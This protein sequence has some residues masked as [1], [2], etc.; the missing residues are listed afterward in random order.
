MSSLRRAALAVALYL[1]LPSAA[2]ASSISGTAFQDLDRD[3]VRGA[4]EPAFAD[5]RVYLF[6]SA[7]SY[8]ANQL[9]G[10]NG[11]YTFAGLAD[12]DYRVAY[13]SPSW[14]AV[15]ETWVPTTTGSLHPSRDVRLAGTA[16][17]DFGW[18]PLVRS[19]D[20]AAPI[21][22]Y[23]G[24]NG[25]TIKSYN[26]AVSALELFAAVTSGTV[27]VEAPTVTIDF[28]LEAGTITSTSAAQVNGRWTSFAARITVA[29]LNWLDTGDV[30][31]SHEYGHAWTLYHATI[32]QQDTQ[33]GGYLQ[34]RGLAGDP[35]V[36][37]SYAWDRREMAAEDYRQLLGSA[38]ARTAPQTNG[39]IPPAGSVPGLRDFLATAFTTAPAEEQEPP[40]AAL[41]VTG[42]QMNPDPVRTTGTVG[43]TLSAPA[44]VSVAIQTTTGALV[45]TLQPGTAQPAGPVSLGWD[46]TNAK[47]RKV[48]RGT[49][50]VHVTATPDSGAAVTATAPFSVR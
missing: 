15:R 24:A 6:D 2:V 50:R 5:H 33:F 26:D 38:S 11:A 13:A 4:G 47:G 10:A 31:L 37:S 17:A 44:M 21:S 7:G 28:G 9:T 29:Y 42:L 35:R 27:G 46:R 14:W 18:R 36:D 23:V 32:T 34:A 19:A 39:A 20:P 8:V 12:G 49:Y 22:T 16:T 41:A 45:K 40:P 1:V 30:G 43:F 25:L 3:G 48:G